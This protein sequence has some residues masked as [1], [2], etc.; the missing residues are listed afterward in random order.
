MARY[1]FD[2]KNE[3][4]MFLAHMGV[5]TVRALLAED[6]RAPGPHSRFFTTAG[7][8]L[9]VEE[10]AT[11]DEE[12]AQKA[13]DKR[14]A[15]EQFARE[16]LE[17][18]RK[19]AERSAEAAVQANRIAEKAVDLAKRSSAI[20]LVSAIAAVAS[21][22]T[23]LLPLFKDSEPVIIHVPVPQAPSR[24]DAPRSGWRT[25]E[26]THQRAQAGWPGQ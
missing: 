8:R 20:A 16:E 21:A 7:R 25:I 18:S 2:E 23:A 5:T 10:L 13:A 6:E 3:A 11:V 19:A 26:T 22:A 24:W 17:R 9:L 14:A 4:V 15:D 1:D 12:E